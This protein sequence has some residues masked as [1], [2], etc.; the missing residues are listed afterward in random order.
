[1]ML[2]ENVD[3]RERAN[4]RW[5]MLDWEEETGKNFIDFEKLRADVEDRIANGHAGMTELY[6]LLDVRDYIGNFPQ[7]F[8]LN[9]PGLSYLAG[10]SVIAWFHKS[11]KDGG[12]RLFHKSDILPI[13]RLDI[14]DIIMIYKGFKNNG[15]VYDFVRKTLP[16]TYSHFYLNEKERLNQN[17]YFLEDEVVNPQSPLDLHDITLLSIMTDIAEEN[18]K[19]TMT[20]IEGKAFFFASV[21]YIQKQ[22]N[23]KNMPLSR[24]VISN[25]INRLAAIGFLKKVGFREEVREYYEKSLERL[26]WA[27]KNRLPV[28]NVITYFQVE[29]FRYVAR[30]AKKRSDKLESKKIRLDLISESSVKYVFGQTWSKKVFPVQTEKRVSKYEKEK[31]AY[32]QAFYMELKRHGYVAKADLKGILPDKIADNLWTILSSRSAGIAKRMTIQLRDFLN[33]NKS[34]AVFM[35]HAIFHAITEAFGLVMNKEG[36][37]DE[38]NIKEIITR[39][40]NTGFNYVTKWLR[41]NGITY[42]RAAL[43]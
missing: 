18:L 31:R 9:S 27:K 7:N 35:T 39:V 21:N 28:K 40:F 13:V 43:C 8:E 12:V 4:M 17:R 41:K 29:T 34:G 3:Q 10:K 33:I 24:T 26:K 14:L 32:R 11:E 25:R 37:K 42:E 2:I 19:D 5:K 16:F 6:R 1:M 38:E 30:S 23:E 36:I 20:P 15:E 22:M